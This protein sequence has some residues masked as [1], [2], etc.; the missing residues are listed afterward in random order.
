MRRHVM[1]FRALKKRYRLSRPRYSFRA[2]WYGGATFSMMLFLALLF[3]SGLMY[4]Y[5]QKSRSDERELARWRTGVKAREEEK[6]K[7]VVAA[8]E[9]PKS[10]ARLR[11]NLPGMPAPQIAGGGGSETAAAGGGTA[12]TVKESKSSAK[13][14]KPQQAVAVAP[15]EKHI[16]EVAQGP[17]NAPVIRDAVGGAAYSRALEKIQS[18]AQHDDEIASTIKGESIESQIASDSRAVKD[19]KVKIVV[20]KGGPNA[21]VKKS[22]TSEASHDAASG[23]PVREPAEKD[24]LVLGDAD[25]EPAS[26]NP[27]AA[28]AACERKPATTKSGKL[29]S[30]YDADGA[31]KNSAKSTTAKSKSTVTTKAKKTVVAHAKSDKSNDEGAACVRTPANPPLQAAT[32][33][34]DSSTRQV[35]AVAVPPAQKPSLKDKIVGFFSGG[36]S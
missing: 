7:P 27:S 31:V 6:A 24:V 28:G 8:A 16:E 5:F 26:A 30:A 10:A 13:D 20:A 1:L 3:T 17:T 34:P 29:A 2:L 4:F 15:P 19:P 36:R 12:P 35:P 9:K 25:D 11:E 21:T 23:N 33:S 18:A 14:A 32:A 22:Q